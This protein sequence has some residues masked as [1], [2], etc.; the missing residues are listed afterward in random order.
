MLF[1]LK[2]LT[3]GF[4]LIALA[5]AVLLAS[6]WGRRRTAAPS[7]GAPGGGAATAAARRAPAR[8]WKIAV[9]AYVE[10]QDSED[11]ERGL[12]D[13]LAAQGLAPDRDY[14]LVVRNAQG[15]MPTLGTLVDAALTD[16]AD[17]LLT[18]STPTLQAAL[19]RVHDRPIVFT[20]CASGV[21]AGAGESDQ[22]H[23]PNVTGVT[24]SAPYAEL[25]A[26]VRASL[27]T[28]KT[29]GTLYVPAE[30]NMVFHREQFAA[31][32]GKLGFELVAVAANTSSE[33]GT[34]ADALC[35]R[36]LD[37]VCQ[38]PGNLASTGFVSIAAAAYKARLPLF[39]FMTAQAEQGAALAACRDYHQAGV[40]SAQ[41]AV[42]VLSGEDPAHIPFQPVQKSTIVFNPEGARRCGL[43]LPDAVRARADFVLQEDG[44]WLPAPR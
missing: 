40:E 5:A 14:T 30:A 44:S 31:A 29:L 24:T 16:G 37:A 36:P 2:R 39:G 22:V 8:P 4:V 6:D 19:R 26:L 23:L 17:L 11:C 12:R 7:G 38:L 13:G 9:V 42:R 1:A 18:L 35:S 33:I 21:A 15:D 27:P 20:Y 32:A 28:A 10:T 41:L 3:L 43:A 34:A 25:A